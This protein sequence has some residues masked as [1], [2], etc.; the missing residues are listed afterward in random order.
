LAHLD[1]A[2]T[3]H[4]EHGRLVRRELETTTR[5]AEHLNWP[6]VAQVCRLMRTTRKHGCDDQ[7]EVEY[8]ITSVPREGANAAQLLAWKRGHWGIENRSHYVRDVTLG[9]DASRIRTGSA[10]RNMAAL[11]NA[12][13]NLLRSQNCV[14]VAATLRNFA[15]HPRKLFLMLGILKN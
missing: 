6:G 5:L 11:R 10:P 13:L 1:R 12:I 14:N 8:G 2:E 9:E 4:K 7:V 3:S 15:Y